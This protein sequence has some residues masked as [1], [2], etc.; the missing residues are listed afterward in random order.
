MTKMF[1][2]PGAI[3][4]CQYKQILILIKF[5]RSFQFFRIS[6]D[7]EA[8]EE[9]FDLESEFNVNKTWFVQN[10]LLYNVKNFWALEILE[11]IENRILVLKKNIFGDATE[12]INSGKIC[13]KTMLNRTLGKSLNDLK[14]ARERIETF[15]WIRHD[16]PETTYIKTLEVMKC[17]EKQLKISLNACR[18]FIKVLLDEVRKR[19][20]KKICSKRARIGPTAKPL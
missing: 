18:M 19:H 1:T 9:C 13:Y 20:S 12:D 8:D 4:L 7:S 3:I 15:S 2:K 17:N 5:V 11:N 16:I 14:K 6:E 10:V